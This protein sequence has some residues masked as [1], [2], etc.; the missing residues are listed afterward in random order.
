MHKDY[1]IQMKIYLKYGSVITETITV[2][3][4]E[5]ELEEYISSLKSTTKS[6]MLSNDESS[7]SFGLTVCRG[8][9]IMAFSLNI[10][11]IKGG[12]NNN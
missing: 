12:N 6:I 2:N 7:V 5:T 10:S 4:T 3:K 11:E 9:Q 1:L 8:S